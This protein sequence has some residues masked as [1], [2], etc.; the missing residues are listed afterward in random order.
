MVLMNLVDNRLV[1]AVRE[2]KG[3]GNGRS[4]IDTITCT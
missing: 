2:G 3:G 1:D 4:S